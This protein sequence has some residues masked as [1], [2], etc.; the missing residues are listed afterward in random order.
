MDWLDLLAVQ[1]TLK[2]LLQHHSSKAPIL[3][4]SAFFIVQLSHPYVTIGKTTALTRWTFIDKVYSILIHMYS[5]HDYRTM[6]GKTFIN[7]C[8]GVNVCICVYMYVAPQ[9]KLLNK[10]WS[11]YSVTKSNPT[12][13]DPMNCSMPG[14]PVL[15]YLP[16]FV[17]TYVHWIIDV[18]LPSHPLP[19]PS[20]ATSLFQHRWHLECTC[21][22]LW[23]TC[24][25]RITARNV[26]NIK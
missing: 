12:L 15:R 19:L 11:F 26:P 1:G 6:E 3:L 16:E 20:L 24:L 2:S 25:T 5:H 14:F 21:H 18:I 13:F 7:V 10:D 17:H 4:C 23:G 22:V 8:E 9:I